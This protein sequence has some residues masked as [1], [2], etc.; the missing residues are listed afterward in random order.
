M[1]LT[2][3]QIND[4]VMVRNEKELAKVIMYGDSC[5]EL[6]E[7]IV[8]WVEKEKSLFENI[9]KSIVAALFS[10]AFF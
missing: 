9:W 5:I 2:F 6:H 10:S 4:V 3:K 1:A 8:G 7:N